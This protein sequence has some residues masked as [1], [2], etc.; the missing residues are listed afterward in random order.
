[1]EVAESWSEIGERVREAREAADLTQ[2]QLAA[3]VGLER[4]A[5]VRV[6]SG[7]RQLNAMELF[8]IS[9]ALGVPL[10]HFVSRPPRAM[11]S[12]RT[13][14]THEPTKADRIKFR[15]TC[16]WRPRRETPTGW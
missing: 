16:T 3:A 10:T 6:E 13:A 14:L 15:S 2:T 11:V 1:M 4:I 7:Q 5:L 8:R 9:D 12:R